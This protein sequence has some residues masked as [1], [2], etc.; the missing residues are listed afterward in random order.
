MDICIWRFSWDRNGG[1]PFH[2]ATLLNTLCMEESSEENLTCNLITK[3]NVC[4][5]SRGDRSILLFSYNRM[6]HTNTELCNGFEW[7]DLRHIMEFECSISMGGGGGVGEAGEWKWKYHLNG[8]KWHFKEIFNLYFKICSSNSQYLWNFI[9][10][11][12]T[13]IGKGHANGIN[14]DQSSTPLVLNN[15]AVVCRMGNS[16]RRQSQH[17]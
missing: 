11:Y 7:S 17:K 1:E 2:C 13:W 12:T 15:L 8:T 3:V 16:S 6:P 14:P 5:T 4:K 9:V 10:V